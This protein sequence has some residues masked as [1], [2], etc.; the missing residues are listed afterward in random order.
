VGIPRSTAGYHLD[1]LVAAGLLTVTYAR[2]SGRRGPGAG[3]PAKLYR[4]ASVEVTYQSPG[5][6]DALLANLFATAIEADT[7]GAARR[8]LRAATQARGRAMAAALPE[9]TEEALLAEL[10]ER[11][12]NPTADPQGIRLRNCP[13]HHLVGDHLE[14]VC[15]L[16]EDLLGAAMK[17]ADLG[18]SAILDPQPGRCCVVLAR[19]PTNGDR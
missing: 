6:D 5:R 11:G 4:R 15:S 18:F 17:A 19:P 1:Q 7:S 13:F 12:Y 16:N 3:R 10:E 14:L 9:A 2:R 8:A